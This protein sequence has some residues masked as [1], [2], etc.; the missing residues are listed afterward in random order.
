[1]ISIHRE[2]LVYVLFI[3]QEQPLKIIIIK[4]A[5]NK[6]VQE[7]KKINKE[8]TRRLEVKVNEIYSIE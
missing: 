8:N 4:E 7:I 1:M 5:E 6:K 2:A 3:R